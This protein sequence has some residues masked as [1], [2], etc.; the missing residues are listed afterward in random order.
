MR[1]D[2][3]KIIT[4]DFDDNVQQIRMLKTKHGVHVIVFFQ[5]KLTIYD[6]F[7]ERLKKGDDL[8]RVGFDIKRYLDD[9]DN[10]KQRLFDEKDEVDETI[11]VNQDS[12]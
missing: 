6:H 3:T 9:P 2:Y 1:V 8:R 5:S 10:F 4:F 12:T 11:E 7:I